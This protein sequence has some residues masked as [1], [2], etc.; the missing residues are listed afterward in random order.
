MTE[1]Y[2]G[3]VAL[4]LSGQQVVVK[5]CGVFI[6]QPKIRDIV[7]TSSENDF[8][9]AAHLLAHIDQFSK[10]IKMGKNVLNDIPDFQIVIEVL[11]QKGNQFSVLVDKFFDLCLPDFTYSCGKHSI[12]FK[13]AD[14]VTVGLL[15]TFNYPEFATTVRELFLPRQEE[16]EP[17]Y[18]IDETDARS[19]RL[20]EKIK[21]NREALAKQ[22]AEKNGTNVSVFALYASILSVGLG[23]DI[24][25]LY[26]YTPFQ[27]FDC[28]QRFLMKMARDQYESMLL[29]PF[30]DTSKIQENEPSSW[31][32]NLYKP[33]AE[34]YNSLQSLNKVKATAR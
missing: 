21:R 31:F 2:K 3:D 22:R 27:L 26:G 17:E 14:G 33:T 15:N 9:S 34:T 25:V 13:N 7:A 10:L 4:Y 12:D 5:S 6:T 32:E 28:F 19:R 20:L 11:R 30:A 8:M 18:H 24:N 23:I 1:E 16:E 29:V